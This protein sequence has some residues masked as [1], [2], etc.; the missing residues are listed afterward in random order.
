MNRYLLQGTVSGTFHY[1]ERC[2]IYFFYINV[3][4][5]HKY[6]FYI[7]VQTTFLFIVTFQIKKNLLHG[8]II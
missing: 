8:K 5:M 2:N 6:V 3:S 1:Q 4:V 7:D